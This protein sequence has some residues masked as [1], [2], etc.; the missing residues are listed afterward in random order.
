[1]KNK[2]ASKPVTWN[3]KNLD[4]EIETA[5]RQVSCHCQQTWNDKNLDYEIETW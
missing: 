5:L 2:Q 4:Y 3:D 1:M